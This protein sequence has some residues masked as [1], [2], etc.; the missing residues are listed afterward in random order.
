MNDKGSLVLRIGLGL[1]FLYFSFQ[2]MTNPAQWASYVPQ[3]VT[4]S[5]LSANN[6]VMFNSVLELCLGTFI[7]IGLYTRISAFIL[8]L[9]LLFISFSI[10]YNPVG[11][12]DFGLAIATLALCMNHY[13]KCSLDSYFEKSSAK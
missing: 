12:R 6:L 4:F 9:H 3:G 11:V 8:G 7:I 2:Q 10:G 1:V 5:W 13:D